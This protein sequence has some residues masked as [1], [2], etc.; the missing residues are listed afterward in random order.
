MPVVIPYIPETITV[1]LGAPAEPAENVTVSFPD[2]IKNVASSEIYPT[3]DE[4]AIYANIYAQI[5]FALNRIYTEFYPAQGYNFNI[6]NNTAYDQKFIYG[7]NIFDNIDRIVDNI[8]NDYIRRQ[9]TLEPI[10]A[11]YCNGTT[12]T[13]EGLSQW[14]SQYL[15]Q[16]GFDSFE[17]L[18][19]YYGTDIEIVADAPV[20]ELVSSYP[21]TPLS[22]GDSGQ[23]VRILQ[24]SLNLIS[25]DYPA[26]P[27]IPQIDGVFGTATQNAVIAFQRIFN[28]N[29]DGIV[30]KAT[31]Y[32]IVYLYTGLLRL[33]EL[34][35]EG[36]RLY[37]R[38]LEY[39]DAISFGDRG[40]KVFTL[41]YLLAVVSQFYPTI[42]MVQ[43]DGIFGE[44]TLE[45]VKAFQR[46][47]GLLEDGIVGDIT[48][49]KLYD[50]Y[51]GVVDTTVSESDNFGPILYPYGGTPLR[52]GSRG[53]DVR[54]LQVYINQFARNYGSVDLVPITGVFSEVT[55][56][57]VRQ[58]QAVLGLSVDGVVGE[59]T[60]NGIVSRLREIN[61]QTNTLTNQY[62]GV[63]LSRNMADE[64]GVANE[65]R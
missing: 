14:G 40:E 12:V 8:F 10:A 16:Q 7:R 58:V 54:L 21:G 45:A 39:P 42:P 3:W 22:F 36:Q 25:Q 9:G 47:A 44:E 6:T 13:C 59:Q 51:K 37:G 30:G 27:K 43:Q 60:W 4:S 38:S 63:N 62:S 46:E 35:S 26:I 2:Y 56:R 29:P 61:S 18:Q 23:Y 24:V 33:S 32:K 53:N 15:A 31:W 11:K 17:I 1:H 5:T 48:W 50:T 64:G 20:R 57:G 34:D 65:T 19:N 28:L 49:N 41:Q 55:A 52:L